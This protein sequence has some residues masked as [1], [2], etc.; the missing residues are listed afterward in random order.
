MAFKM[1]GSPLY[2]DKKVW[3][4]NGEQVTVDDSTLT[5]TKK[6]FDEFGNETIKYNYTDEDGNPAS[7]I[8]Y[9]NKPRKES[10]WQEMPKPGSDK[11]YIPPR[12][13]A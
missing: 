8:L 10:P 1:K 9:L 5:E 2:K 4:W 13:L 6:K 11:P 3:N 7:D 12:N